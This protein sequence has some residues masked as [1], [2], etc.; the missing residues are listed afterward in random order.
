MKTI[1]RADIVEIL[2]RRVH[3]S[4]ADAREVLNELFG[5]TVEGR[6]LAVPG[7]FHEAMEKGLPVAISGF[8]SF[9][10]RIR[11]GQ[12]RGNLHG[13]GTVRSRDTYYPKFTP[14]PALKKPLREIP[15][16]KEEGS[17]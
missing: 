15:V 9:E 12:K 8:G 7:L 16:E 3:I 2:A 4:P 6:H 5:E 1:H 11:K 14:Y 17:E 10:R 13:E